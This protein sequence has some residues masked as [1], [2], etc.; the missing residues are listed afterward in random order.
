MRLAPKFPLL[1]LLAAVGCEEPKLD[2]TRVAPER[3]TLGE[4]VFKLFHQDF[5]REENRRADGFESEREGFIGGVDHLFPDGELA[6]TQEFLIRLLPLYD[7]T[8]I[9]GLTRRLAEVI[10][11]LVGDDD[12]IRALTATMNR[13]G[14]VDPQHQQALSL[15]LAR[16]PRYM[17]LTERLVD[18]ALDHDGLDE[19]G[20]ADPMESKALTTLVSLLTDDM[21]DLEISRD[22]QRDIVLLADL[23]LT[24]DHRL[25]TI[26][27]DDP[28]AASVVARDVRG[29]ASV[30]TYNGALPE[31]FADVSGDGLPD[32]DD[33]GRFVDSSGKPIVLPPF[34]AEGARDHRSRAIAISNNEL[35]YDYVEMDRTILAGLLRDGRE[36]IDQSIPS[37]GLDT[38]ELFLGARTEAGV[39]NADNS[40]F[41]E[42]AHAAATSIDPVMVPDLLET[43]RVLLESH[44]ET[45]AWTLVQAEL[46]FDISD[47]Y[48]VS[49]KN[50]STFFEELMSVLRKILRE[51][52]LAEEIVDVLI[53]SD[54]LLGF[55]SASATLAQHKKTLITEQDVDA[56]TVFTEMVDRTAPDVGSNQSLHQRLLHLI[57]DTK[58]ARYEP[59]L[60]GIPLGFI[61]EINDLAEFYMLSAI[62]EAEVPSLVSTLTGLAERPTPHELAVFINTEQTFGNAQGN[63]GIDVKDNDGDT[64]FAATESGMMD[65]IRPLI[66]IFHRRGKL[67]LLFEAFEVLHLHWASGESDYQDSSRRQPKYSKLSGIRYYE[68]LMID[69]YTSSDVI[70]AAKKLLVETKNFRTENMKSVKQVL[71]STARKLMTKDSNLKT[72]AGARMVTVD[73]ERITPLSPFDL[74]RGARDTIRTTVRRRAKTKKDWDDIIDALHRTFMETE[75]A[76]PEAGRFKNTRTLPILTE[77][78]RFL[79]KR[80]ERHARDGDLE[81]WITQ[82]LEQAVEDLLTSEGLPAVIDVIDVLENDMVLDELMAEFRDELLAEDKGFSDTLAVLGDVLGSAKDATITVPFVNFLGRE[83]DP[84]SKLLFQVLSST[85]K[86]LDADPEH[87][88]L[89]TTRRGLERAPDGGLYLDGIGRAILQTNR[90]NPLDDGPLVAADVRRI[91]EVTGGYMLDGQHGLEKFYNMVENRK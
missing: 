57:F 73:G 18:L 42:M 38:L 69:V 9:P 32:I 44:H 66:E 80:A 86:M 55:P 23:L 39:Y 17:D 59:D 87:T 35:V 78:V 34:G 64:L 63:E 24:E 81:T 1:L 45:L 53:D 83:L 79:E 8:T 60:I 41:M 71:L 33:D 70:G 46:Q 67:D 27:N 21:R 51:P 47:R 37:K 49:L 28:T 25:S 15:R 40:A 13:E 7:D 61:F 54:E 76:G 20:E 5:E 2:T 10:N 26:S 82:D 14:Y 19:V 90:V 77:V 31:P 85:K 22:T 52:G 12:A 29:M 11:R 30:V 36:L 91:F 68:P 6:D 43:V 50:D 84:D 4:E 74:I 56:G 88:V 75:I 48:D 72:L 3:G 89:E 16:F 58:G 65:A 62:G